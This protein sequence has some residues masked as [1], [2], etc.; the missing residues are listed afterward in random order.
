VPDADAIDPASRSRVG[1]TLET[2]PPEALF[3]LSAISQYIGAAI[4]VSVFDQVAPRTVAWFRVIG[5]AIALLAISPGFHRGWTR[6]HL[7]GAAIFGVATALMNLFFYLAIDRIDLGKSVAIEFLGPIAVAAATTRTARNAVA[8]VLAVTGVVTLG[9][10]ELGDNALGVVF[11]LIS[12]A[13]WAA[14]IVVGS[15]VAQ[16]RPGVAGLGV[17]LAIGSLATAPIGAPGSGPVWVS[18][19]L[20]LLCCATGVFSNAIGYGIDQYVLRRIPIRRFSLLLATLPVT[21]VFI[22]WIAL[23]Q[24]PGALDLVGI[25]LVLV[26]VAVQEREEI[27]G[28]PEPG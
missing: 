21:A 23:G 19:T 7:I 28:L 14:Y 10:V 2:A 3:V 20:L 1:H 27:I 16:V 5:A 24:R 12:S 15:R 9:G 18:P 22:G 13:L 6:K 11:I 25:A 8:L 26:G 17:A 4:A